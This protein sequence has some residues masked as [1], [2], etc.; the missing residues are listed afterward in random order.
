MIDLILTGRP[1]PYPR[2]GNWGAVLRIPEHLRRA[3]VPRQV[4]AYLDWKEVVG[5]EIREQAGQPLL[6]GALGVKIELYGK[7][8]F[9]GDI[10]NYVKSVLD[11]ANGIL[12]HDDR[13]VKILSVELHEERTADH[14]L[15][16]VWQLADPYIM[17]QK[18]ISDAETQEVH[19][20]GRDD[21][22]ATVAAA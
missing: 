13:Q 5:W 1:V 4:T 9:K 20:L 12:W 21:R 7:G 8:V 16:L 15:L 6:D 22:G 14:T 17:L 18:G 10:D 2:I 19:D 11:A 3:K